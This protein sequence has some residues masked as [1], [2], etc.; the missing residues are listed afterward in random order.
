MIIIDINEY[1]KQ[2][3]ND[4]LI[5]MSDDGKERDV[6]NLYITDITND[7]LR[8]TFYAIKERRSGKKPNFTPAS[9]YAFYLGHKIHD[10][11]LSNCYINA[12]NEIQQLPQNYKLVASN[13]ERVLYD[14]ADEYN[15]LG[16]YGVEVPVAD[17]RYKLYGRVDELVLNDNK[18]YLIDK[19]T[20]GRIPKEPPLSYKKQVQYYA[21]LLKMNYGIKCNEIGILYINKAKYELKYYPVD[22]DYDEIAN[23]YED[24]IQ[25]ILES[26]ENNELPP[27]TKNKY[28]YF[29]D[30]KDKCSNNEI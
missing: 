15:I 27:N 19:K 18:V 28:C 22:F 30:Y 21:H 12:D 23:D 7:C 1:L 25:Y 6:N 24:T 13:K 29:C 9:Y 8:K 2:R 4:E 5:K 20:T 10:I 16:I 26:V 14:V 17:E 11:L 3:F